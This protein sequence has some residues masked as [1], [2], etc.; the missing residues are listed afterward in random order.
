M[1]EINA[2]YVL[3][4]SIVMYIYNKIAFRAESDLL[5]K[6]SLFSTLYVCFFFFNH[7]D[8]SMYNVTFNT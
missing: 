5:Q 7:C 4:V 8:S 6:S 1:F 3:C 2:F